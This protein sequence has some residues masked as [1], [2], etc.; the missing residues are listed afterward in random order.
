MRR[1]L[2]ALCAAVGLTLAPGAA[3]A[4][5]THYHD[6]PLGGRAVGLGGAF[7]ALASDPS[8]LYYNPAGIVDSRH[9]S[10]Q[11]GSNLYGLEV[12]DTFVQA[13]GVVGDLESVFADLNIIP[14]STAFTGVLDEDED[15][16]PTTSYALGSF[17]PSFRSLNV[18][19]ASQASD[20]PCRQLSYQRSVLDRT[21]LFGGGT[22]HR[23]D[24][25]WQFGTSIFMAYRSLRDREE[26]SCFGDSG[27]PGAGFSAASTNLNL[28]AAAIL[29][30]F[31]LKADLGNGLY[32]GGTVTSPSI[33]AFDR[34]SIRVRRGAVDP[35]T[36]RSQFVLRE[37]EDLSA[38]T[39]YGT[40][41]R[42]GLAWVVPHTVTFA[43]D[44]DFRAPTKYQL[45]EL[46]PGETEVA[47]AITLTT[48]IERAAV[49]NLNLGAEYLF[50]PS[51][52]MAAGFFTNFSS[53]PP[54]PGKVGDTFDRDRLPNI[55]AFGGSL[56]AGFFGEYTLTRVGVT[57]SYGE[58]A[59][60]VPRSEGLNALGQVTDYVKVD[61]SQL[62]LYFFLSSTFRY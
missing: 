37:L 50:T 40:A 31:G 9:H 36:E 19:S 62:F 61:Y 1:P 57:M 46:P 54:I 16:R 23:L 2:A 39:R 34:G 24:D 15:G 17:I 42:L 29:M 59:D 52:S 43:F 56:V 20:G 6:Y 51:F 13:F 33:P 8:G 60:V 44:V 27:Q 12:S 18:D 3:R 28:A 38:N 14:S 26:V 53:A 30:T 45:V 35:A 49:V 5:D 7:V 11:I 55:D 4:D 48:E 47:D 41:I 21:F 58:G 22:A 25:T 10:V 32:L